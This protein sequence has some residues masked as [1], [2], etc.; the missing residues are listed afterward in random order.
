[1]KPVNKLI[2]IAAL[3]LA[4]CGPSAEQKKLAEQ[5]KPAIEAPAPAP[6]TVIKFYKASDFGLYATGT[7][8]GFEPPDEFVNS[9]LEAGKQVDL[10]IHIQDTTG[11]V[12]VIKINHETWQNLHTGD[13]LR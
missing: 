8:V 13:V 7:V 4:S 10:Y 9:Q 1:M 6:A 12:R 2:L 11:Y 3:V 5:T